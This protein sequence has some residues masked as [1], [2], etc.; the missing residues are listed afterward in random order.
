MYKNL[1]ISFTYKIS[2]ST[3]QQLPVKLQF[4]SAS[5]EE[6]LQKHNSL[7]YLTNL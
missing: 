7:Y 6:H 2:N 5:F 4:L 1:S 3:Y